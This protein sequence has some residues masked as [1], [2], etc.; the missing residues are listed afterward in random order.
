MS[1]DINLDIGLIDLQNGINRFDIIN[2]LY[3]NGWS[4]SDNGRFLYLPLEDNDEWGWESKEISALEQNNLFKILK[5]KSLSNEVLG[6][7]M[8][9]KNTNIGGQFLIF[10]DFQL[11]FCINNNI[12]FTQYGF[13]DINWYLEKILP[14]FNL[15]SIKYDRV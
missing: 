2:I 9:W 3:T 11:S 8:T 12:Q 10:P 6:V 5:E 14:I 13:V 7:S 1:R 15:N 4:F